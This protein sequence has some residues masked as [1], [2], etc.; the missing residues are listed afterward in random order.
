MTMLKSKL[1]GASC[2][3]AFVAA[4]VILP[5]GARADQPT[6]NLFTWSAYIDPAMIT[7]FEKQCGCK[8][9]ETDYDSN[10]EM[11]AKLKAGADSQYDVVVPSSYYVARL[12]TEGLIQPLDHGAITNFKNLETKF[13]N[14]TYDPGDKYSIPYQWG[15][16][17]VGYLQDQIKDPAQSWGLLFDPKINTTYPFTLMS[18]SGQDTIG[19]AC[20]YLG[21][22]FTCDTKAEWLAAAKL[23]KETRARKNFAGF[24]DGEPERDQLK[25]KLN[26][27]GMVFNGD[28][29]TSYADGSGKDIGFF[30]PKEGTEIWVD[31]MAI[32]AHAPNAKL[33]LEF[34]NFILDAK[35]GA[36]LSNFNDYSSPN[37]ASQPMLADNLKARL[38]S[39]T[40]E[41]FKLL[42]FLPP[43]SGAKLKLFNAIWT[44]SKQ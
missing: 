17:G 4:A 26:S 42:H 28:V 14:P 16:T 23:I 8:V 29:A 27:A 34:I 7:D 38:V 37:A 33:G 41:D 22:G 5:Q 24:V 11:E 35:E 19:A 31:T 15:T 30:L 12:I 32:P 25:S 36:A 21:Y 3:A 40:P 13:Q 6:L 20:A 18:G 10:S 9:V 1:L 2:A 44:A 39:P 43:L